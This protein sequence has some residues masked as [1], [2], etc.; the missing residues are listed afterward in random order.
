VVE[1]AAVLVLG[2]LLAA[3]RPTWAAAGLAAALFLVVRPASVFAGLIGARGT[4]VRRWL[5]GW[6]GIRGVGSLYYLAYATAHGLPDDLARSLADLVVWT[7]ALSV[8]AHGVSVT[9]LMDWYG[10]W[11]E[12]RRETA[13]TTTP[14]S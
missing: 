7:V 4:T 6:F 11:A 10:T 9:P 1:V 12:R 5:A 8:V 13:P 3:T 2:A 14:A